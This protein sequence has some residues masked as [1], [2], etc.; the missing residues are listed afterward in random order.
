MPWKDFERAATG[1]ESWYASARGRRV[2]SSE[3]ALLSWLVGWFPGTRR[4]LEIGCGTGHFT[5]SLAAGGAL[6]FG[7]DRS[8]A[9]LGEARMGASGSPLILADAH[10]LP[11]RDQSVDIAAFVTTLEFLES[12][13]QALL[14]SIRVAERGLVLVVLNR[15]SVGALSRRC[16]PQSRG[17]LLAEARDVSRNRLQQDL[18]E[19]AGDRLLRLHWR[20]TLLPRPFDRLITPLPF[21]DALGVAVELGS[22][23][24]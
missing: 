5:H 13:R 10:R 24:H 7:L 9:M 19:A 22:K 1:Y 14:E 11:L 17:S 18:E 12:P 23:P 16:G 4:V 20:S 2:D 6:A 8:P 15:C 3:R 21:G